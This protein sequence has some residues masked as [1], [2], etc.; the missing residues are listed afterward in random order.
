MSAWRDR[1]LADAASWRSAGLLRRRAV[2]R[3]LSPTEFEMD[4]RRVSAFASNDYLGLSCHPRLVEALAE[5]A[6]RYGAGSGASHLV[7]GHLEVHVELEQELA[8]FAGKGAALTFISG[9]AA[10]IAL[11]T[12]LA[13][14]GDVIF[15][16]ELNHASIID[17][18]RLSR[19]AVEVYP[20]ADIEALEALLAKSKARQKVVVTDAVFSMDGDIAPLAELLALC[21]RHD[22]LLIVDDAHG[23]G[24]CGPHGRGS[25]QALG[26]DSEL[27]VYMGTL[28]K[29]AGLSG[30][31]VAAE[32]LIVE[33]LI[34]RSRPYVFS[35]AGSP[36]LAHAT[37]TALELLRAAD[38]ERARLA[39]HRRALQD[40]APAWQPYRLLPSS[41][42]IQPLV[43]GDN[44]AV[45]AIAQALLEQGVWAPAIRPP[46]VPEGSARLRI[47]LSAAHS[48]QQLGRLCSALTHV[49][50]RTEAGRA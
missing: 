38:G 41:T 31:F 15:S 28:G 49:L 25:V 32:P 47:A 6:R 18:A 48:S 39:G 29:A 46:T 35:T 45:V 43:I 26:L 5:G 8:R 1:F 30:A 42:A 36:A 13:G 20:H 12:T 14:E 37:L 27:I 7:S 19:A 34:Q 17:G 11:L 21:E 16:D 2:I 4:G 24:V 33:R 40:A 10:N 22:A 3:R 23:I 9:Y 50:V 44:R